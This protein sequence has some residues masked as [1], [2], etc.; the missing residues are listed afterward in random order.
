M[1]LLNQE[2]MKT[3]KLIAHSA[4]ILLGMLPVLGAEEETERPL[5]VSNYSYLGARYSY[6]DLRARPVGE[7]PRSGN[8]Q[9]GSVTLS[10]EWTLH[11]DSNGSVGVVVAPTVAYGVASYPGFED[12]VSV[13][14]FGGRVGV[15]LNGPAGKD[16]KSPL[17]LLLFTDAS[18]QRDDVQGLDHVYG[19]GLEL[20]FQIAYQFTGR[21]GAALEYK[22]VGLS[23]I[24]RVENFG[25]N[26][27]R[28]MGL[29]GLTKSLGLELGAVMSVDRGDYQALGGFIGLRRGF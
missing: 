5:E 16:S 25:S 12:S 13:M 24:T 11:S 1:N 15:K 14:D 26:E 22:Y 18:W 8:L 29:F 17:T 19:T 21:V 20:G 6:R 2:P 9:E 28:L 23:D 4:L 3:M 7:S 27:L 10:K